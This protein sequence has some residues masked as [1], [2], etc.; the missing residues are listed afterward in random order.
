MLAHHVND[1]IASN[2]NVKV[3]LFE[4]VLNNVFCLVD[5][6]DENFKC[7]IVGELEN[8]WRFSNTWYAILDTCHTLDFG[9]LKIVC[10]S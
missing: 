4:N 2:V 6:S 8:Q 5:K 10:I 9:T 3:G 7:I 1:N